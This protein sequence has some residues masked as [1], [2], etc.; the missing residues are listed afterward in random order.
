MPTRDR[1][2]FPGARVVVLG[3]FVTVSVAV[4][5]PA[6]AV[7][8]ILGSPQLVVA[9]IDPTLAESDAEPV[10]ASILREEAGGA[11]GPTGTLAVA[12]LSATTEAAGFD[13]TTGAN[14]DPP[15]AFGIDNETL[16][17]GAAGHLDSTGVADGGGGNDLLVIPFD[18]NLAQLAVL[19]GFEVLRDSSSGD[20]AVTLDAGVNGF[21]TIDLDHGGASS[22]DVLRLSGAGT[23]DLSGITLNGVDA[24][25]GD[26]GAGDT[27]IGT[28]QGDVIDGRGGN[29]TL[30]GG[31]DDDTLE[32]GAGRDTLDGG[33]GR[34]TVRGGTGNDTFLVTGSEAE[35]DDL[36]GGAGIDKMERNGGGD[37]RL[38]GFTPSASIEV[39]D[40]KNRAVEGNNGANVL[41]FSQTRLD[42]LTFVD[43]GGG[44]DTVHGSASGDELRGGRGEDGLFGHGGNDTLWGGDDDDILEG[45][46]GRDTLDGGPGRD[47]VSGG[48]GNDTFLVLGTEAELDVF[49]G[50]EGSDTILGDGVGPVRLGSFSPIGA[51]EV[52]DAANQAI[53]GTD[54]ANVLDFSHARLDR[55]SF[56]DGGGG[57][58]V[59]HGSTAA[60][61]L[62]GGDGRDNLFGDDD[63][64]T[65]QGDADDDILEGN[66]GRDT[67]DGGPGRDTVSGGAGNDTFLV[68]GS[69]AEL[70]DLDGGAGIDKM[71]RNGGGDIRLDGFTP[72]V[73]IEVIDAKNRAVEGNGGANVLDFSQTRLDRL[74]FADGGGGDDT[75]HGSASGDELR[76]GVGDDRLVGHGGNDTLWGGDDDDTLE[77]GAGRDTLDGG[78]GRDTVR[79][80]AGNDTFLVTGSEAELDDLDG[81][82]GIDKMVRNGGG[83]IRLD[84]FTPSA[85]IE[86][87]DAKNRAVEGTNAANTLDLSQTRLD[88]VTFIGAGGGDDVVHGS[89]AADDLRGGTGRDTL[90]GGPGGDLLSGGA[91]TDRFEGDAPDL[92]GDTITD[93]APG[94][95]I[96]CTGGLTGSLS[97]DRILFDRASGVLT[98][99]LGDDGLGNGSDI[100]MTLTGVADHLRLLTRPN[101]VLLTDS[102]APGIGSITS[103]S[104]DGTFGVGDTVNVTVTFDEAVDFTANGGMLQLNLSN[105]EVVTLATADASNQ[106][107]VGGP[108]PVME[109]QG[110]SADLGVTAVALIGGATLTA[111]ADGVPAD[112][113]LP[114]GQ[115]L[116]DTQDIVI[117]ANTPVAMPPDLTASSDSGSSDSDDLTNVVAPTVVGSTEADATVDVRVGG[118]GIGT[119]LADGIGDWSFTFSDGDL[120]EG[121]NA[122]DIIASDAVNTGV[123]SPDLLV[124]LDTTPPGLT[125]FVRQAPMEDPTSADSL[126]FRVTFDSEVQNVDASDFTITG[127]TATLSVSTVTVDRVFDLTISGGDLADQ[128]GT[129][130][131]DLADGQDVVDP[132][133]NALPTAEPSTDETYTVDNTAPSVT[134]DSLT[135]VDATPPLTGT[136]DDDDATV[137]VAVDGQAL[138]ATNNGD[139]TWELRDDALSPL[140]ES[141]YDVVVTA[142]DLAGN[143]AGDATD[144]ELTITP[145]TDGDGVGDAVERSGPNAGDGNLDGIPDAD[146]PGVATLPTATGRGD[147]TLVLAGSCPA[148]R[149]VAAVDPASLPDDPTGA[150]YPFGLVELQIPCESALVDVIYHDVDPSELVS[151]TYRQ[152]GP[153]TPGNAATTGWYNLSSFATLTGR[154]WNLDLADDRLG[155]DTGNDGTIVARGGPAYA[156]PGC[157][158][159]PGDLELTGTLTVE[160]EGTQPCTEHDQMTI[161][162]G[163]TLNGSLAIVVGGGYDSTA[164]VGDTLVIVDHVGAGPVTGTFTGQPEGSEITV[165]SLTFR[166]SYVGGDGNDVTLEII[167]VPVEL[168]AFSV[169]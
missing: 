120:G 1:N 113:A 102:P 125:A 99:D 57:D 7:A 78:P 20:V 122:I 152:Y 37:I 54:G 137:S 150:T 81:G 51:I 156:S 87:I 11:G 77:G 95:V 28:G 158:T 79:G 34:D 48:A 148:L 139:G 71:V 42:R 92:D 168:Q 44:D 91:G 29:D 6:A 10:G 164:Q 61:D 108:Y 145:D 85:S 24:I 16:A 136:I 14:L 105:G 154:T 47:T 72:S 22:G 52:I 100:A 124:T 41:S 94:E 26:N 115:S 63:N 126:T 133:G 53:V 19:T 159:V 111:N 90:A 166:V 66:A 151:S 8:P 80:G 45:G 114:P 93:M 153:V 27:I 18:A 86:V 75:V 147:A 67:L 25:H 43:G 119:S 4:A 70:D 132:A 31:G 135:T 149:H 104:G 165:G 116:A 123:D 97:G 162:G 84:G 64:D 118:M 69:E 23:T 62:R 33:P 129:V 39:I 83:D 112:L 49:D 13:T 127:T 74:T 163:L 3:V 55:V 12:G 88:R 9:S 65:L 141:T 134:V 58:D 128:D 107:S 143:V 160:I 167:G 73:S 109:G 30:W 21:T 36:D 56:I 121:V 2:R 157:V 101:E 15:I 117:D 46:A 130:G 76:G 106:T 96:A 32:G 169:E 38:D 140:A 138:D 110:D 35:L 59:V 5:R 60:D 142:T 144:D 17:I 82:A 40:A 161:T 89:T 103:A 50:G 98:I 155:D 131:L 146:Q 68:T